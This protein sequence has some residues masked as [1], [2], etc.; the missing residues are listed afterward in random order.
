MVDQQDS[1]KLKVQFPFNFVKIPFLSGD[2]WIIALDDDYQYAM[3]GEKKRSALWILGRDASMPG[4]TLAML[5][6]KARSAGFPVEEL[7]YDNKEI[8]TAQLISD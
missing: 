7:I 8:T 3:V 5:V 4:E 6:E 2:Y 1:A